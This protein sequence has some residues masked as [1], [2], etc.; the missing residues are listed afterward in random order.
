[1]DTCDT[2]VGVTSVKLSDGTS[3]FNTVPRSGKAI[4]F[5]LQM[6]LFEKPMVDKAGKQFTVHDSS[7]S[8]RHRT[9]VLWK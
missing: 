2:E 7:I 5:V 9:Q 6:F 8:A 3:D 1:M 4:D